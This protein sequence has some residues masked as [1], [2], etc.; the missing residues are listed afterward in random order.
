MKRRRRPSPDRRSADTHNN[1]GA[2]LGVKGQYA[3]A[4]RHFRRALATDPGHPDALV[5]LGGSLIEQKRGAEAVAVLRRAVR[6]HPGSAKTH[7]LLTRALLELDRFA[8]ALTPAR[9]A[10][11]LD[12]RNPEA[13]H[14]LGALLVRAGVFTEGLRSFEAALQLQPDLAD[15]HYNRGTTRLMLGALADG[16]PGYE[17]RLRIPGFE[18]CRPVDGRPLWDGSPLNGRTILLYSDQGMGDTLMA[19]RY[20]SLVRARGGRVVAVVHEPLVGILHGVAGIDCLA[21]QGQN[22]TIPSFD[23][24]LPIMSLPGRFGTTLATIPTEVPYLKADP[25][26]VAAWRQALA[27]V[28]GFRIGIAWQGSRMHQ[29]DRFRSFPLAQFDP[30][31]S[32]PNVRLISLQKHEGTEQ[33]AAVRFPVVTI[34]DSGPPSVADCA[35]ILQNLDLVVTCDSMLAHLAGALAR[36]VWI[37]LPFLPDWRWLLDR[38]DSPWY[39]TARLF[40]QTTSGNWGE[41]FERIAAAVRERTSKR[42]G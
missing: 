32:L 17:W 18:G 13:H 42:A 37:A 38:D 12:T 6:L 3:E 1:R 40:R 29:N 15:T 23:L 26:R 41:V 28:D 8:E 36:P 39:P 31:A 16:W 9:D 20:A 11:R 24:Q 25:G 4:E 33:F 27:P 21:P 34:G 10:V 14:N 30:L 7:H 2:A 35:A 22:V 19:I 5:N